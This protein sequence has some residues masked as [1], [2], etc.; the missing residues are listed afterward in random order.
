VK[1]KGEDGGEDEEVWMGGAR[2]VRE[3]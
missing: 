3:K 1:E 2:K